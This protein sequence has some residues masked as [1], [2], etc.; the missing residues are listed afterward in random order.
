MKVIKKF[1]LNTDN[2]PAGGEYRSFSIIGDKGA[3]FSLEIKNE[4]PKYYNFKTQQFQTDKTSLK[5]SISSGIYKGDILFPSIT[6]DDQYDI[7]LYAEPNKNTTHANY[8]EN[9][10]AD[11]TID[12]NSSTG[13]NSSLLRK[14][15]YQ[16]TN[17]TITLSAAA[18]TLSDSGE[19]WNGVS[20]TADT[21]VTTRSKKTFK[22]DFSIVVTA[23][24]GH[25]ITIAKQP[26]NSDVF[27]SENRVI[28]SAV[29]INNEDIYSGAARSSNKVV[30]STSSRNVTMDDDRGTF[31]A[32]GDRVTGNA[33]LDAKTGDAAVTITDV[34]VGDNVKV[35][36]LSEAIAIDDDETL[37]F[38]PQRNYRWSIGAASSIHNLTDGMIIRGTNV[39]ND[40]IIKSYSEDITITTVGG[41][42]SINSTDVHREIDKLIES[43][44]I[45]KDQHGFI[46]KS[47]IE[48]A[49]ENI[50]SRINDVDIERD[51][52]ISKV[53]VS[54]VD[55]LGYKPTITKGVV[56]KQLG[57]LTFNNQ[58]DLVLA[59]DTVKF[60]AYNPREIRNLTGTN[61]KLSDLKVTLTDVTTTVNDASATGAAALSD[62]D[63]TSVAGIMDD[64]SVVTGVNI[65]SSSVNPTGTA[66]SSSNLTVSP[67]GHYLQNGQTLVF[68]N[69]ST[70]ATITGTIEVLEMA[71]SSLT[72][73]FDLE[74]FLT[75]V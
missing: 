16:Y 33:A 68:K 1:N 5:S 14:V 34:D 66:I 4:D 18:P 71:N 43:Q 47:D 17:P 40:S 70:I 37:T 62:F 8:I 72:I 35:F 30:A 48:K 73:S 27:V 23:G 41:S 54:G 9:R 65:E 60:Y 46:N 50:Q 49:T 25:S 57:N 58:Q 19:V 20:I 12:I 29:Q 38:I 53:Q 59:G 44:E 13:S 21:L 3:V 67:T 64:V 26:N 61:I 63:V 69:A 15:I 74:R 51:R 55:V 42:N 11:G 31:W 6:D 45:L 39:T 32:L 22:R 75:A 7:Y 52:I 56:T 2:I 10:F 28:G 24:S 36:E